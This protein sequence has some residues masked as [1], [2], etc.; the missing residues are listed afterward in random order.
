MCNQS[1]EMGENKDNLIKYGVNFIQRQGDFS[2]RLLIIW[3]EHV[4]Y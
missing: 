3:E 4:F 1:S 2:Q